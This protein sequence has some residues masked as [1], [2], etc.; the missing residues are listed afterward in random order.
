MF[1]ID[2]AFNIAVFTFDPYFVKIH[3]WSSDDDIYTVR[4]TARFQWN[5]NDVAWKSAREKAFAFT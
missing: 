1:E 3:K 4:R 2:L 5:Y